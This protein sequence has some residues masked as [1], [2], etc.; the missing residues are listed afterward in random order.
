MEGES[1][2]DEDEPRAIGAY[3]DVKKEEDAEEEEEEEEDG[4]QQ[5]EEDKREEEERERASPQDVDGANN[6]SPASAQCGDAADPAPVPVESAGADP[7]G[8]GRGTTDGGGSAYQV[9]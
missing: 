7:G 3:E 9:H 6:E 4:G 2:G 5:H 1:S 8:G